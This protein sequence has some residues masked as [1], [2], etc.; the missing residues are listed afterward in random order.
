MKRGILGQAGMTLIEI[1]VVLAIIAL[2]GGVVGVGVMG[3]LEKA[4]VETA[5][6]QIRAL[7]SALANYKRDN[8]YYPTT[9]QGLSA[10]VEKPSAGR[11]PKFYPSEGYLAK[12]QVPK[13]PWKNDYTYHSPG[14]YGHNYEISSIG[15]DE[16]DGTEDDIKSWELTE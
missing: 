9:D 2:I 4:K 8:G 12:K 13:D 6:N 3:R 7:E 10:L 5:Q 1:M 15:P 14:I 11:V 16:E